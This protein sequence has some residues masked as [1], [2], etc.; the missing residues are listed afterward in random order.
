MILT[1]RYTDKH[2]YPHGY[3]SA[4]DTNIAKTFARIRQ[5]RTD[6]AGLADKPAAPLKPYLRAA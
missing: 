4:C 5:E 2:K 1:P 3:R 6:A